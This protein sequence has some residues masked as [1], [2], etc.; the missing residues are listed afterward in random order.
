MAKRT[1]HKTY[2]ALVVGKVSEAEGYIESFI[3]RD[4]NNRKK[5][6]TIAP[7]N[8]KLAKTKFRNKGYFHDAYTLLE[9]DLLTGRTHQ[10]RV[11][12]ASIGF[13]IVGDALYGNTRANDLAEEQFGLT[14]QWLHAHRLE[15]TLFG[16]DYVFEGELKKDLKKLIV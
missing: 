14:R 10:I 1:I 16:K 11:H 8:P 12:L 5:M 2:L 6:S 9:V 7:I 3:G 15:F 4:P 13:P